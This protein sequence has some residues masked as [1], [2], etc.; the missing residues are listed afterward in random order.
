MIACFEREGGVAGQ[1][2]P[3]DRPSRTEADFPIS[4][5]VEPSRMRRGTFLMRGCFGR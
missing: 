2:R 5:F 4:C 1:G 3:V